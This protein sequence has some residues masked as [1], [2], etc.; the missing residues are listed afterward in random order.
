MNAGRFIVTQNG[1]HSCCYSHAIEDTTKVID[2]VRIGDE[3]R[4]RYT[5]VA[6]VR[7]EAL[8]RTI[9]DELNKLEEVTA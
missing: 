9:C 4:H 2:T 1:D 7:G 5:A 6:E 8:A 3:V